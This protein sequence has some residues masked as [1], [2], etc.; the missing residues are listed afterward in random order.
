MFYELVYAF[1]LSY[2]KLKNYTSLNNDQVVM[3]TFWALW[4]S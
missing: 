1:K 3:K 2:Y 4:N